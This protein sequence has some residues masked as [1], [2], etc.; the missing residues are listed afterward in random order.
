MVRCFFILL[1]FISF[2][3]A[4]VY[5]KNCVTCHTKLPVSI[6]K[7][8]FRY[9]LKY[10]SERNVKEKL[11]DY[12]KYPSKEKTVMAE[13]FIERFGVKK[14]TKLNDKELEEAVNIYW[15]KYKVFGKLK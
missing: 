4:D 13:G 3:K 2:I 12:L 6:D 15:E 5:E 8:F 9:L 10:S 11:I 1:L 14:S 7:F